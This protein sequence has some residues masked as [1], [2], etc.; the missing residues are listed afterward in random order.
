MNAPESWTLA[1]TETPEYYVYEINAALA[2]SPASP[3][4]S[5]SGLSARSPGPMCS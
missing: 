5:I 1:G 4:G 2:R 3:V